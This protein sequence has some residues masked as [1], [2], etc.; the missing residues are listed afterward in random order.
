MRELEIIICMVVVAIGAFV[1]LNG[2]RRGKPCTCRECRPD[3]YPETIEQLALLAA[4]DRGMAEVAKS[5]Q[6]REMEEAHLADQ[7]AFFKKN[8]LTK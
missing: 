7:R 5:K 3:L 6:V 4:Y 8:G 2:D 1:A